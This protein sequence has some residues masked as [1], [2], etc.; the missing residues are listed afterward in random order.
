[1]SGG[2][3]IGP[4]QTVDRCAHPALGEGRAVYRNGP[5][6]FI[7]D[8]GEVVPYASIDIGG[9]GGASSPRG[10]HSY[11]VARAYDGATGI[12]R[13]E[14]DTLD[15]PRGD[16]HDRVVERML[17]PGWL[18]ALGAE[19]P[20]K[21]DRMVHRFEPDSGGAPVV[22]HV[23]TMFVGLPPYK[24]RRR[25]QVGAAEGWLTIEGDEGTLSY[26]REE[27]ATKPAEKPAADAHA[28][29]SL[30]GGAS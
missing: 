26:Q 1:M 3:V 29:G 10:R 20:A 14:L 7:A 21:P 19:N 18:V 16:R 6:A 25:E 23:H 2:F 13:V 17:G 9:A 5:A 22:L 24:P 30:F 12:A 27:R 4:R 8:S 28:Q 15:R 11:I